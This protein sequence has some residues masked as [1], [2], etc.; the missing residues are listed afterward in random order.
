MKS[1]QYLFLS[2]IGSGNWKT[3][4]I[5]IVMQV[6]LS[7]TW[8]RKH[9]AVFVFH[10]STQFPETSLKW[11]LVWRPQC[12]WLSSISLSITSA[13]LWTENSIQFQ[14]WSQVVPSPSVLCCGLHVFGLPRLTNFSQE[15]LKL[16]VSLETCQMY[17]SSHCSQ[18]WAMWHDVALKSIRVAVGKEW[19]NEEM[20]EPLKAH[21]CICERRQQL[22][23]ELTDWTLYW[24][25]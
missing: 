16:C 9:Y 10:K 25:F 17:P 1:I 24:P 14:Y 7:M 3:F 20:I 18:V 12:D 11:D 6:K 2:T 4:K 8:Q 15:P 5:A 23:R 21:Y 19:M 22:P 13:H